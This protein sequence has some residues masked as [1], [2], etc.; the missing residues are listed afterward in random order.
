MTR[1]FDGKVALVTGGS[2]GIGR[3]A[4]VSFA[5]EGA[6]VIIASRRESESQETLDRIREVGGIGMFV[7]TDVAK[8]GEVEALTGTIAR[9]YG[10][11]DCAFNNAGIEG[12]HFVPTAE[13]SE[14]VWDQVIDVNLKGIWL[15]MKYEIREMLKAGSGAIVNMSSI[16]GLVGS[17]IGAAYSASKHGVIGLTQTGAL[18]YAD[19][20]IRINAVCPAVIHTA[21]AERA[22]FG[23]AQLLA[24]VT[25]RHPM[26]RLGSPEEVAEVVVWLCSDAAS[27]IT[28][29]AMPVDG[30]YLAQ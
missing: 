20:G 3:A 25:G 26:A 22:F 24:R 18:E 14:Q 6:T 17:V 7:R 10:R 23:D 27:F 9:T 21:M 11:L 29:T 16:A 30:G 2:G 19:K 5:R 4:A 13:Y 1:R 8:A 12:T 28:G 15:C